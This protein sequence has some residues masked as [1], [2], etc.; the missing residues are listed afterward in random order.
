MEHLFSPYKL[1]NIDLKNRIVMPGL[2]SFLIDEDGTNI[3]PPI[4]GN[5]MIKKRVPGT[6]SVA[7]MAIEFNHV[8]F[9]HYGI[10]SLHVT[11][12]GHEMAR[13]PLRVAEP[14][15]KSPPPAEQQ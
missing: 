3:V 9:P 6:D 1:K 5:I 14:P 2:A 8:E 15:L 7:R 13:I 11:V 10:Y 4:T 12:D